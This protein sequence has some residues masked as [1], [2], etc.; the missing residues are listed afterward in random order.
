VELAYEAEKLLLLLKQS[1]Q[2]YQELLLELAIA[3]EKQ[4]II[5]ITGWN[6]FLDSH[7]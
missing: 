5:A 7:N 4:V 6:S 3:F 1:Q 2:P